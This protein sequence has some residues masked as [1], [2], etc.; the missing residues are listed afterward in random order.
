MIH[1]GSETGV[2]RGSARRSKSHYQ[3]DPALYLFLK[4]ERNDMAAEVRKTNLLSKMV[5]SKLATAHKAHAADET[6]YGIV[7]LPAGI[8]GGICRLAT[9]K[10]DEYK[11]GKNKGEPYAMFRA[12]A[13]SPEV[14]AD[15]PV[16]G[17]GVMFMFPLCE[18]RKNKNGTEVVISFDEN[19][20]NFLNELRKWGI[21]TAAIPAGADTATAI[22][23]VML[24]LQQAK[25]LGRFSTRGW[26]PPPTKQDPTPKEMVFTQFDGVMSP[27]EAEQTTASQTSVAGSGFDDNSNGGSDDTGTTSGGEDEG[28]SDGGSGGIDLATLAEEAQNGDMAAIEQMKDKARAYGINERVIEE[29]PAWQTGAEECPEGESLQELIEAA[30]NTSVDGGPAPSDPEPEPEP[31]WEPKVKGTCNYQMKAGGK[32]IQ[33]RVDAIDKKNGFATL[34]NLADKKKIE[35]VP[36]GKL[37][38]A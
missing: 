35:K 27:E 15:R 31:T 16:K 3:P 10:L 4:P 19:Y 7:E 30:M 18:T 9:A 1:V 17:Q 37:S 34:T 36:L 13:I 28:G 33:V 11:E 29:A 22:D 12:I 32:K 25:P 38:A 23:R 5:G 26:T 14:H 21:D 8:N 2:L 6:K 24:A 20:A